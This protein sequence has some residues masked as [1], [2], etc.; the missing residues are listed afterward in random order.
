MNFT[1]MDYN[2]LAEKIIQVCTEVHNELGPGL[3]KSEYEDYTIDALKRYGILV[4]NKVKIP[5]TFQGK[6]LGNEFVIDLLVE[7]KIILE[8]K[9]VEVLLPIHE[10]QL[11]TNMKLADKKLGLLI[12]FNVPLLNQGIKRMINGN[13]SSLKLEKTL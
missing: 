6:K 2:A 7:D 4:N 1:E 11:V 8:L 13:L 9:A 5:V 12:N 10:A 3:L